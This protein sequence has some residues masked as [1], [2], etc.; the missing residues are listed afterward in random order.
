M[1]AV[2]VVVIGCESGDWYGLYV[3]EVLE[4]EGHQIYGMNYVDL[5][6]KY[7]SFEKVLCFEISDE[8]MEW[9]G[10]SFP[11]KLEDVNN[12]DGEQFYVE[13]DE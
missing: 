6:R 7:K 9:L 13:D 1:K 10:H 12:K 2:T 11:K 8:H 5:I 4:Y 3:D